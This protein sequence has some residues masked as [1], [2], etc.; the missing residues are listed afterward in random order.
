M[1]NHIEVR[2]SVAPRE[3]AWIEIPAVSPAPMSRT[4]RP[5]RARGLKCLGLYRNSVALQSRPVRAR[6]LKFRTPT[7]AILY[8]KSRP[9][10]GA[11]IEIRSNVLTQDDWLVTPHT[12]RVD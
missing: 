3:G 5:V 6:G 7:S 4:S 2:Y 11:W 8:S 10:R 9:T 1:E 12:G